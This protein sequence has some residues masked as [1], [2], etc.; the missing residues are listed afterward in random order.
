MRAPARLCAWF[1]LATSAVYLAAQ[2][3][4]EDLGRAVNFELQ[5]IR[6]QNPMT[7][8]RASDELRMYA[9]RADAAEHLRDSVAVIVPL[10]EDPLPVVRGNAAVIVALL[11]DE[12]QA[13]RAYEALREDARSDN[14][15]IRVGVARAAAYI[16]PT[17][18][19]IAL[20]EDLAQNDEDEEVRIVAEDALSDAERPPPE[21]Q[22]DDDWGFDEVEFFG[23]AAD[24]DGAEEQ[25]DEGDDPVSA[26]LTGQ[27]L[28]DRLTSLVRRFPEYD[29]IE[30]VAQLTNRRRDVEIDGEE[31][32]VGE[33][34]APGVPRL[35]ELVRSDPPPPPVVLRYA[36]RVLGVSGDEAFDGLVVALEEE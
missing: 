15:A 13:S 34:L 18:E 1:L 23:G 30:A 22:S 24:E 33:L 3:P 5:R 35:M 25:D 9:R 4:P 20:L 2:Q 12:A 31:M 29:A 36:A 14:Y 8:A 21:E 26:W 10:L 16:G 19:V 27:E 32:P 17:P 7:R 11:G 6:A 28:A